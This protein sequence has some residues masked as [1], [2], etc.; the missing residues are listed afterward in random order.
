MF[1]VRCKLIAF[2][3]DEKTF[4]CHF[5]Y[6]IGDEFFY[7]GVQFTG[8]ICQGL[9]PSMMP[10]I[11]GTFLLG[12]KYN[13]NIMYRYRGFDGHDP[14]MAKYDGVGYIPWT[15]HPDQAPEKIVPLLSSVPKTEKVKG[16]HFVCGD[17]RILAEFSCEAVDISD[18]VYCQP[19]YR[20]EITILEKIEAEPGIRA[21]KILDKFT[22]FERDQISPPMSPI[23]VQVILEALTDMEYIKIKEG[24]VYAIGRQPPSRP[25]IG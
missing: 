5:G 4:P 9:F 25:R 3:G 1:N 20:R 14:A 23:L 11:K 8:K 16:G 24:K 19:F 12:N 6:K 21:D 22:A 10:V 7:D 2:K 15:A 18:S 17:T 13:E